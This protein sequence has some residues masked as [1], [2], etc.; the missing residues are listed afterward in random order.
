MAPDL[1]R[2]SPGEKLLALCIG[3][4]CLGVYNEILLDAIGLHG[5]WELW[6][7]QTLLFMG[8]GSFAWAY[9]DRH[10]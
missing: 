6:A 2:S 4:V 10:D 7:M 8:V 1:K 3:L 5:G 9:G